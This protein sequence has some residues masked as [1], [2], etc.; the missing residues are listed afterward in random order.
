M[1]R[2]E[3]PWEADKPRQRRRAR[4]GEFRGAYPRIV[5][6]MALGLAGLLVLDGWLLFKRWRYSREISQTRA[7]LTEVERARADAIIAATANRT[8]LQVALVQR[9]AQLEDDLNLAVSLEKSRLYLQREGALLREIPVR[10]GPEKSIGDSP[11]AVKLAAPRGRFTIARVAGATHRWRAPDWL[12]TDRGQP[13][14]AREFEGGLGPVAIILNG[15]TVIYS[16]P[17]TGPLQDPEYVMPGAVRASTAD[18]QAIAE[19]L[20]AGMPVYFY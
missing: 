14:G 18:L 12:M 10:I 7:S 9:D 17:A 20:E 15:G 3:A 13:A 6:A 2:R 8:Q 16:D 19:V 11:G 5:T 4:W 1:E